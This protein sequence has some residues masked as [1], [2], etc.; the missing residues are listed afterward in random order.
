MWWIFERCKTTKLNPCCCFFFYFN[1]VV[2]H[3]H[4]R[5]IWDTRDCVFYFLVIVNSSLLQENIEKKKKHLSYNLIDYG[6]YIR[7]V[8]IF[9]FYYNRKFC[10]KSTVIKCVSLFSVSV[11]SQWNEY[12][13]K[14]DKQTIFNIHS[15]LSHC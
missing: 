1:S 9:P 11:I 5:R 8:F 2:F 7:W 6:F 3:L 15:L 14:R 4:I 12:D 10:I 13:T